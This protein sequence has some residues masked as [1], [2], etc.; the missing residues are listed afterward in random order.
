MLIENDPLDSGL[1][2]EVEFDGEIDDEDFGIET[3]ESEYEE[4]D[5]YGEEEQEE[6]ED[7]FFSRDISARP[8]QTP[9]N[10]AMDTFANDKLMQDIMYYRTLGYTD[11]QILAG[12]SNY[13]GQSQARPQTEEEPP[14]FMSVGEE[15]AWYARQAVKQELEQMLNPINEKVSK[16]EQHLQKAQVEN[17]KAQNGRAFVNTLSNYGMDANELTPEQL[18]RLDAAMESMYPGV[19]FSITPINPKMAE[20]MV[21]L[22]FGNQR[23]RAQARAQRPEPPKIMGAGVGG[24]DRGNTRSFKVD[25][26]PKNERI[27]RLKQFFG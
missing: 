14:P 7:P 19:D 27:A 9:V 20:G 15:A 5:E 12:M 1:E 3:E 11:E 17:I 22:A 25:G 13:K 24:R 23:Q 26:V 6:E 2:L 18:S 16:Y 8:N 21:R 10:P 4:Y